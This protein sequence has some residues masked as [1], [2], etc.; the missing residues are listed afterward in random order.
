MYRFA[1]VFL[2]ILVVVP[3]LGFSPVP[4]ETAPTPHAEAA[5]AEAIIPEFDRVELLGPFNVEIRLGDTRLVRVDGPGRLLPFVSTEVKDGTLVIRPK[6]PHPA[7]VFLG[8]RVKVFVVTP[9][10]VG[11]ANRASGELKLFDIKGSPLALELAGSGSIK[12]TGKCE[13]LTIAATGS[14][15]LKAE[16][17]E[18]GPAKITLAGSG[19]LTIGDING[20]LQVTSAG[21]GKVV[22]QDVEAASVAVHSSA[23]GNVTLGGVTD[24]TELS[25]SGSGDIAAAALRARLAVA[26]IA[27]SGDID[28]AVTEALTATITGTGDLTYFGSSVRVEAEVLGS[29]AVVRGRD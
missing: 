25:V 28:V 24:Q 2:A 13:Q 7:Y 10:L 9:K 18:T 14:G 6:N 29:G 21:S 5:P 1:R 16:R 12:A 27:G 4:E 20:D 11:A 15:D 26:T 23:S 17:L 8:E 22:I 19:D 3:L